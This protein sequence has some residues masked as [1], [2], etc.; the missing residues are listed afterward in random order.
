MY[1]RDRNR[2]NEPEE[3]I[4]REPDSLYLSEIMG[5]LSNDLKSSSKNLK[6]MAEILKR[7][8]KHNDSNLAEKQR[9]NIQNNFD[10]VRYSSPL[11]LNFS[12]LIVSIGNPHG[13]LQVHD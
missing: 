10:T 4:P 6:L 12:K 11:M 13:K 1:F 2:F 3:M 5:S 8:E 9:R 7:D